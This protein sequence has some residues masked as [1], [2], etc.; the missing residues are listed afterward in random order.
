[1]GIDRL[2]QLHDLAKQECRKYDRR[3]FL[4]S[5]LA[6]EKGRHFLGIVGAR[7]TGKTVELAFGKT[8]STW[9]IVEPVRADRFTGWVAMMGGIGNRWIVQQPQDR[10]ATRNGGDEPVLVQPQMQRNRLQ[11]ARDER[12]VVQ[13]RQ[14]TE[15]IGGAKCVD[16]DL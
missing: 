8:D 4:F 10:I 2:L 9:E 15:K 16:Q 6:G 5:E 3:R 12:F 13:Q 14:L 1:M 7:G 11:D